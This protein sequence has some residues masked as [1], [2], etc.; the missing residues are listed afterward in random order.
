V[1]A[2]VREAVIEASAEDTACLVA[3]VPLLVRTVLVCQRSGIERVWL[4]GS[5]PAPVDP[6]IRIP[7]VP[8]APDRGD[9]CLVVRPGSVVDEMLVRAALAAGGPVAWERAGARIEV[10]PAAPAPT[11][12][13]RGTLL[14]ASAPPAIIERALLGGFE[15]P[16]EGFFDR[17]FYRRLSRP[18][19]RLL[20]RTPLTPNQVTMLAVAVGIVGGLALGA[21]SPGWVVAGIVALALSGVL[22]CADGE[23]ARITF[24]EAPM[25]HWLD[26]VGDTLVHGA[27][28]VGIAAALAR[29]GAWPGGVTLAMLGLGVVAAF[30]AITWSEQTETRRHRVP[31]AWENH[32]LEH[33]LSPL[34][35]RDWYVF[36]IVLWLVGRLDLLV[37]VAAWGAHVFWVAVV[38]LVWRVLARPQ[39]PAVDRRHEPA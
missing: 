34:S 33:V 31:D 29:A 5:A 7:V 9:R 3:G 19:T 16:R 28:L 38:V 10:G 22:D 37:S 2:P 21:A 27:V 25:G 8:G 35:T 1:S 18:T 23:L 15:N 30:A 13:P 26:V 24:V 14:P 32:V 36:P 6:R 11:P 39:L 20:L 12:P 4:A 17:A